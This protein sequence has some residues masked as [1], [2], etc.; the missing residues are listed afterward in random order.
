M[1]Q[2]PRI[3]IAISLSACLLSLSGCFVAAVAA[4]GTGAY[5]YAESDHEGLI[6]R[7]VEIVKEEIPIVFASHNITLTREDH[8]DSY[9]F[10]YGD[11]ASG[12]NIS[13]KYEAITD[14]TTKIQIRVGNFGNTELELELFQAI[15]GQQEPQK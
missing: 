12:T 1:L 7:P 6:D 14:L 5:L 13:I 4:V 8:R 11:T 9:G 2:P 3:T 10:F 15:R